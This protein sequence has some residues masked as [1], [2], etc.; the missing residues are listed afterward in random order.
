MNLLAIECSTTH[1][2][3]C[4]LYQGQYFSKSHQNTVQ[5]AKVLLDLIDQLL[6]SVP[7]HISDLE[8][9]VF[10]AGPGSFTGLRVAC[11]IAKGLAFAHQM[12]LYPVSGLSAIAH[13]AKVQ[14]RPVLA[15][16]D[17]R[18]REVYWAYFPKQAHPI[19][20]LKPQVTKPNTVACPDSD[21]ILA[22]YGYTAYESEFPQALKQRI[23]N[24]LEIC[25]SAKS[26]IQLVQI[27][28][29]PMVS[30]IDAEPMYVRNQVV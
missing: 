8:G 4:L 10:G 9:L 2:S 25:P 16:M 12:P 14:D 5:H 3:V 6:A 21:F 20:D 13:E 18:M 19:L 30:A 7:I 27:G 1:A 15:M 29:V 17:A 22:G 11:A 23:V 28:D 26:M 24:R